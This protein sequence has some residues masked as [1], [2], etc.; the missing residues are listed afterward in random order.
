[1]GFRNYGYGPFLPVRILEGEVWIEF[2]TGV[3][4]Y[5][6][7]LTKSTEWSVVE[8]YLPDC[9]F[10]I[11]SDG[12]R[13]VGRADGTIDGYRISDDSYVIRNSWKVP[14]PP[15]M[16][17][18]GTAHMGGVQAAS[19]DCVRSQ[20]VYLPNT[21]SCFVFEKPFLMETL[22][23][24]T[25]IATTMRDKTLSLDIFDGTGKAVNTDELGEW[26]I[27]KP[28]TGHCDTSIF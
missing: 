10:V 23:M 2:Q 13:Y 20:I 11:E 7:K 4:T 14:P 5:D 3:E 16:K 24:P 18:V 27:Q 8:F 22:Y 15:Q 6:T 26:V 1:M 12:I 9:L 21:T 19:L 17:I 28:F 25:A